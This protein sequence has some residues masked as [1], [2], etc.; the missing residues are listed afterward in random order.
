[1]NIVLQVLFAIGAP[2]VKSVVIF[3]EPNPRASDIDSTKSSPFPIG[4]CGIIYEP[5]PLLNADDG[6][7]MLNREPL[8]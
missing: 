8:N 1:M 6:T 4:N 2:A 5:F 7:D 3:P